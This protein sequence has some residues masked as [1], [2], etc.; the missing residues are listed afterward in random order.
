MTRKKKVQAS[1]E[2]HVRTYALAAVAALAVAFGGTQSAFAGGA[3]TVKVTAGKPSE[4]KFAVSNT[5]L[6]LGTVTFTVTNAGAIVHDFKVCSAPSTGAKTTCIGKGTS[7]LSPH[8]STTMTVKFT[9]A[10]T[11]AYLCTV[12]GHAAAGMKGTFKVS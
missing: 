7:K 5:H 6:G 9:K 12:P 4:F 10:G 1:K 8:H 11:Y 2:V 3:H